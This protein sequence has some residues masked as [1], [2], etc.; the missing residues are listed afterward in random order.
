M[1]LNIEFWLKIQ[2]MDPQNLTLVT[3]KLSLGLFFD[4]RGGTKA[5]AQHVARPE[6]KTHIEQCQE[7]V[8][9]WRMEEFHAW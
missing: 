3:I 9:A 5:I 8:K 7:T 4:I 6:I 2:F 1:D